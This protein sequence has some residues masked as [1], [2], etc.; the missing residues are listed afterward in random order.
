MKGNQPATQKDRV[1]I[2]DIIRGFA[3]IGVLFANF[4]SFADQQTPPGVMSAISSDGDRWL[5]HF[6]SIFLEWK[7]MTLFSILFGYGFGLILEGLQRK[8]IEPYFFFSKRMFWLFL[9]GVIHCLFWW[10]D[11]LNLYAMSG[12]LLLLFKNQ[13]NRTILIFSLLL[14]F[15]APAGISYMIR[16]RPEAFTEADILGLY[17]H[18]KN[19]NLL[20]L[21]RFNID[22]YDRMFLVSGANYHDVA[23]TLGRFLFG[24]FLL[25]IRFFDATETRKPTFKKL[26]LY[27]SPIM[28]AYF[29]FRWCLIEG[30]I[31]VNPYLASILLSIGI[32]STTSFYV[33]LLVAAYHH[34]GMNRF[35]TALQSLGR[36]TLTNYLFVSAFLV[37]LLYGIGFNQLGTMPVHI[38]WILGIVWVMAEIIFSQYWLQKFRYGPI[39]WIWRQLTYGRKIPLK[40]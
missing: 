34:F 30:S 7:F 38:I 10:G 37:I 20:Q 36:M 40:K 9:F 11:V 32:L 39:E 35:F 5:M 15:F 6:N 24:Y 21:F 14:M 17:E 1:G 29:T 19:D 28:V 8:N 13:S 26:M 2:V 4:N 18:Y 27:A 31:H 33:G 16:N 12:I 22:F 23:Q 3:L 25:R